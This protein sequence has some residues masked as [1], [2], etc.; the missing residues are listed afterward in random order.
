LYL[1]WV[2]LLL[3]HQQEAAEDLLLANGS[4]ATNL[5]SAET[6]ATKSADPI[7]LKRQVNF[8]R[9]FVVDRN[10]VQWLSIYV[11]RIFV[12]FTRSCAICLCCDNLVTMKC[13]KMVIYL[14]CEHSCL[15]Y[16]LMC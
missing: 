8:I 7:K 13:S 1:S 9:P 4:E 16:S 10:A 5:S 14:C 12:W 6:L 15:V 3:L 2:F 11:V